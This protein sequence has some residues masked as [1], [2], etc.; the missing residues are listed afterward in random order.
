MSL[1]E[2]KEAAREWARIDRDSM[3]TLEG[4]KEEFARAERALHLAGIGT[5]AETLNLVAEALEL[6]GELTASSSVS[7]ELG[8]L[9]EALRKRKAAET[10][11]THPS[12]ARPMLDAIQ[13]LY[14]AEVSDGR[15]ESEDMVAAVMQS[16]EWLRREAEVLQ[17]RYQVVDLAGRNSRL[18]R[19][20]QLLAHEPAD[21]V[22]AEQGKHGHMSRRYL[23]ELLPHMVARSKYTEAL[24]ELE[25]LRA[26]LAGLEK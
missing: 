4:E 25:E 12:A 2:L 10:L 1:D 6:V 15:A 13:A 8:R 26:R 21:A 24:K 20:I 9:V 3:C 17:L 22:L 5:R 23:N 7:D 16:W 19:S 11:P 14:P 18:G